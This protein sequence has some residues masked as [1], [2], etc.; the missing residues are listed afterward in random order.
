M[1][2]PGGRDTANIPFRMNRI[3]PTTGASFGDSTKSKSWTHEKSNIGPAMPARSLWISTM[4]KTGNETKPRSRTTRTIAAALDR[5]LQ[6]AHHARRDTQARYREYSPLGRPR[7][8]EELVLA[9]ASALSHV[10]PLRIPAFCTRW[11][12]EEIE[13]LGLRL[14]PIDPGESH[15]LPVPTGER[16]PRLCSA[17]GA[18]S[19]QSTQRM[20]ESRKRAFEQGTKRRPLHILYTNLKSGPE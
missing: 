13:D 1:I 10:R 12:F 18:L 16:W 17:S 11:Q 14:T 9:K 6:C 19:Y 5:C 20:E 7:A 2:S 4:I 15:P 3:A 8:L